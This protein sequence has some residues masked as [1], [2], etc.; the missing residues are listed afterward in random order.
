M[1]ASSQ[2]V[3]YILIEA[4]KIAEAAEHGHRTLHSLL[5]SLDPHLDTDAIVQA[6]SNRRANVADLHIDL[7]RQW[8]LNV[9]DLD[10]R[11]YLCHKLIPTL[12]LALDRLSMEVE[13]RNLHDAVDH[14]ASTCISSNFNLDGFAAAPGKNEQFSPIHYLAQFLFR[15]NP[16]PIHST[17]P[18]AKEVNAIS[19]ILNVKLR[20]Q[21][22]KEARI[23]DA[24]R[25][26]AERKELAHQNQLRLETLAKRTIHLAESLT[27]QIASWTNALWRPDGFFSKSELLALVNDAQDSLNVQLDPDL[28]KAVSELSIHLAA[29]MADDS[30]IKIFDFI[31]LLSASAAAT[32]T[33]LMISNFMEII[34]IRIHAYSYDLLHAHNQFAALYPTFAKV[35]TTSPHGRKQWQAKTFELIEAASTS[36]P[37]NLRA[38]VHTIYENNIE[39]SSGTTSSAEDEFKSYGRML[40]STFGPVTLRRMLCLFEPIFTPF[41]VKPEVLPSIPNTSEP[42]EDVAKPTPA[43]TSVVTVP[44]SLPQPVPAPE[45]ESSIDESVIQSI[46][47]LG[48]DV[49]IPSISALCTQALALLENATS[50]TLLE[51]SSK[52]DNDD[53]IAPIAVLRA[54]AGEKFGQVL[55]PGA[56]EYQVVGDAAVHRAEEGVW[57]PIIMN[58]DIQEQRRVM[59]VLYTKMADSNKKL[60]EAAAQALAT[61]I[62]CFDA[63]QKALVLGDASIKYATEKSNVKADLYITEYIQNRPSLFLARPL[64]PN[65]DS[66]ESP[67]MVTSPYELVPV[68]NNSDNAFLYD[69]ILFNSATDSKPQ[70]GGKIT[71]AIPIMDSDTQGQ[72]VALLAVRPEAVSDDGK[73]RLKSDDLDDVKH[74]AKI[75]SSG[76]KV[77]KH[78]GF[79][80]LQQSD[81]KSDLDAENIDQ[82]ATTNLVFGKLMLSAVRHALGSLDTKSLAELRSYRRPPAVVH[83]ICKAVLYIFGKKP[84]ELKTWQA[85]LKHVN[86]QLLNN[87]IA[88]DPTA[89]Q[90]KIRFKRIAS[91]LTTIPKGDVQAKSSKPI[92]NMYTW[93]RVSLTLRDQAVEARKRRRDLFDDA[94]ITTDEA[95]P[96]DADG[97]GDEP[98]YEESAD[99]GH[100]VEMESHLELAT[101]GGDEAVGSD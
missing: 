2:Q 23:L 1:A 72:P 11:A 16:I 3:D 92:E 15:N 4:P 88:Y 59:G 100:A 7:A 36:L 39:V 50:I 63:R 33:D 32:W 77:L 22:R 29:T 48:H 95:S 10:T 84:S 44:V 90:K 47:N 40:A 14:P 80:S 6:A 101:E 55:E 61:S 24:A 85:T 37:S 93:L 8:L 18:Y 60:L 89:P 21:Q 78:V 66:A 71:T 19:Q 20:K 34:N 9:H 13:R 31:Q 75:F 86:H 62:L 57:I 76:L 94:S 12:V 56:V 64:P 68:E 98:F 79:G 43:R 38:T 26:E 54:V 69:A 42:L 45:T 30:H 81:K 70:D 67:Y 82:T 58:V 83:K 74:V 91:V 73:G 52:K 46:L 35:D 51:S 5:A 27:P 25:R 97:D 53:N 49:T 41:V 28:R 17:S 96:A 87:M 99:D 65:A